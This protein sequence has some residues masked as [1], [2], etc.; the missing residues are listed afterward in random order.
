MSSRR[1]RTNARHH[2]GGREEL[3]RPDKG[4]AGLISGHMAQDSA[5]GRTVSITFWDSEESM[6]A[7]EDLVP[8]GGP[9]GLRPISVELFDVVEGF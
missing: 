5:M 1:A 8:P 3:P 6:K 7:L 9:V 4:T 2:P